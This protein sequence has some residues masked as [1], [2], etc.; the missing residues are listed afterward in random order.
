[1]PSKPLSPDEPLELHH[2][3]CDAGS[4]EEV[5]SMDWGGARGRL[6]MLVRTKSKASGVAPSPL[7]AR[8]A[9]AAAHA[10]DAQNLCAR[11]NWQLGLVQG[12]GRAALSVLVTCDGDTKYC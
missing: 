7:A 3:L 11:Q 9:L 6:L 1:M 8:C 4:C 2:M 5:R 12:P 10:V